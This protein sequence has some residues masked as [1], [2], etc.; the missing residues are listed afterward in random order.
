M[1]RELEKYEEL[2]AIKHRQNERAQLRARYIS[3]VCRQAEGSAYVL[4]SILTRDIYQTCL[5]EPVNVF[6]LATSLL[7]YRT[8]YLFQKN[9]SSA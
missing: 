2:T 1:L 9:L 4:L 8:T 5:Q 6:V 7:L 3:Y